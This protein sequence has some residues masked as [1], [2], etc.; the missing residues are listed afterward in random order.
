MRRIV[1]RTHWTT[2]T[3]DGSG[4]AGL[5]RNENC[6]RGLRQIIT[7]K[8]L[9]PL[10]VDVLIRYP[11]LRL[12]YLSLAKITQ[13]PADRLLLTSGSEQAIRSF[14]YA[15]SPLKMGDSHQRRLVYPDP[16]YA[17]VQVYGRLF[18]YELQALPYSYCHSE[19]RFSIDT[20]AF[21]TCRDRDVVYLPS[22]DNLTGTVYETELVERI[23]AA[24]CRV[25]IDHAYID[26]AA[27]PIGSTQVELVDRYPNLSITRSFSKVGGV[28]GM[29]LGYLYSNSDNINRYYEDK[30]MYEISGIS[31]A[32][33]AFLADAKALL[34]GTVSEIRAGKLEIEKCLQRK[35]AI[36]VPSFGNFAVFE[37]N[38]EIF[39]PLRAVALLRPFEIDGKRFIRVTAPDSGSVRSI[40]EGYD[41]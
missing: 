7:E 36:L 22:P 11:D 26:F 39:E 4:R 34:D 35:G 28:A 27:P 25:L 17:M 29:R 32:Y 40:L 5:D 14:L 33:L 15:H 10:D 41:D 18:G 6:D 16:T 20:S 24:G 13:L 9:R 12:A 19:R 1:A 37:E 30:P 31:C 2:Q 3:I 21:L 38:D 23:C 8:F